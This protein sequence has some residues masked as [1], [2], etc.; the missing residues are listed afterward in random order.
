MAESLM[1]EVNVDD[2]E[3]LESFSKSHEGAARIIE[4][5][6][7]TGLDLVHLI[8]ENAPGLIGAVAA[9]ITAL[10]SKGVNYTVILPGGKRVQNPSEEDV[11][12][13]I[14]ENSDGDTNGT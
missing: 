2:R 10:K 4:A 3:H 12:R 5:K 9:L 1:I 11:K 8:I 13:L 6:H 14:A 7:L